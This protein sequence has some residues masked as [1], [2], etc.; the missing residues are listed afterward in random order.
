MLRNQLTVRTHRHGVSAH[1]S[2]MKV[3]DLPF[4]L[5]V[6]RSATQFSATA[7]IVTA[8]IAAACLATA[9]NR[10]PQWRGTPVTPVLAIPSQSLTDSAGVPIALRPGAGEA[11]MVFF[12]YANCPDIC[13][14]TLADWTRVKK[15]LGDDAKRVH[16]V[17]I[18]VDPERDTP[19][20]AQRYVAQFD[21]SFRGFSGDVATLT[22]I[23][24]FFGVASAKQPSTSAEGYLVGHPA[25]TFLLDD[26]GHVLVSYAFGAGWDVMAADLKQ[27]LRRAKH[28]A[29][30]DG[31]VV[32]DAWARPALQG[33]TGGAYMTITNRSDSVMRI[34]SATS[35]IAATTELHVSTVRDGMAHMEMMP[36]LSITPGASVALKPGGAHFMLVGLRKALVN[37]DTMPLTLRLQNSEQIFVN[38]AVRLQ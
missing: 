36:G 32:T 21:S 11:S 12:G 20:V 2:G 37:G 13:P 38:V 28:S 7:H 24:K 27:L 10:E 8:S 29:S 15:A 5:S 17:F 34:V 4:P 23:Q 18:S 26:Q 35:S 3:C 19:A 6:V 22:A 1:I 25:Q 16:F 30:R 9:C 14:T 33:G 31:V